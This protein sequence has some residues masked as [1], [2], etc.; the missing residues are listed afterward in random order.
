MNYE[1]NVSFHFHTKYC[2]LHL[3]SPPHF[4]STNRDIGIEIVSYKEVFCH[5]ILLSVFI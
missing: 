1:R 2:Y 5:N 3:L 4:N